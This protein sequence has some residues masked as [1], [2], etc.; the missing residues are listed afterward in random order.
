MPSEPDSPDNPDVETAARVFSVGNGR[1]VTFAPGNLQYHPA[2]NE[3]RFAENQTDYI[4]KPNGNISSTFDGWI[5]LFGWGTGDDPTKSSAEDA[6]YQTFV[7]WGTNQIG[8]DAP[9]T[10]RTLSKDEWMYIFYNRPNAQS[11][12]GL[13]TVDGVRGIIILPDNWKAPNGQGMSTETDAEGFHYINDFTYVRD[14]ISYDGDCDDIEF[15]SAQH[16]A[17]KLKA[18]VFCVENFYGL[19]EGQ[20]CAHFNVFSDINTDERIG[21]FNFCWEWYSIM[22]PDENQVFSFEYAYDYMAVGDTKQLTA[23]D[24]TTYTITIIDKVI[25]SNDSQKKI[26]F[27]LDRPF[28]FGGNSNG[29]VGVE[30]FRNRVQIKYVNP[31][32]SSDSASDSV[33]NANTDFVASTTQELSWRG[34]FYHNDE[35]NNFSHNVYTSEQWAKMEATG[36][37]FLPAGGYRDGYD[38]YF[39]AD[40]GAYWSSTEYDVEYAYFLYFN[41]YYC[42]PQNSFNRH[43]GFSVRLVKDAEQM[44]DL[45]DTPV[46]PE[47]PDAVGLITVKAKVPSD[48][49]DEIMVWVWYDGEDGREEPTTQEGDWYVYQQE[50]SE[51]NI[52]FKNGY[53]WQGYYYQTADITG[54]QPGEPYC[55]QIPEGES[56]PVPYL[57]D[58]DDDSSADPEEPVIPE[59]SVNDSYVPEAVDLGLSVRWAAYNVGANA[60]EEYGDYFAWGEVETKE[61]YTYQNYKWWT[62]GNIE[63]ITKYCSNHSY[64]TRD[65]KEELEAADDA[66]TANWGED[67]RMPTS[68]ELQELIDSCTWTWTTQNDVNGYEVLGPNGNSIFLP[69]AG[70]FSNALQYA[71]N[72][73]D[74]WTSSNNLRESYYSYDLGFSNFGYAKDKESFRYVGKSVRPVCTACSTSPNKPTN[75]DT[76]EEPSTPLDTLMGAFSVSATKMVTFSPGNLQYHPANNEWRFARTQLDYIGEANENTSSTYN[77][78]R[79]LFG[80]ND[81]GSGSNYVDYG[82]NKIDDYEP[83]TWRTLSLSE[84]R[85]L[86]FERANASSLYGVAQVNGVNGLILLPD[87]WSC[88]EGLTFNSGVSSYDFEYHQSFTLSQ[89]EIL[90][91]SGAVFLPAGGGSSGSYVYFLQSYGNY[92]SSTD[93]TGS[94]AYYFFFYADEVNTSNYYYSEGRNIRLVKDVATN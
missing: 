42:Y 81:C 49:T 40:L 39:T 44:P 23:E 36:A 84:W 27:S 83:N 3:W 4:Y 21:Q 89:W 34:E 82:T 86:A 53:G 65:N 5:D 46:D 94:W 43:L 9:N 10:W 58:C 68:A 20:S 38:V 51:L 52:I 12:F 90:E 78:W 16:P 32:P 15:Y 72:S 77:G 70:S 47:E 56:L 18:N 61:T 19:D 33:L 66:A 92:W 37:V 85:Y 31:N 48:W 11:L 24:G 30:R 74:Y 75:P 69:A 26:I 88:P 8:D 7:D 55:Y 29:S 67:W 59:D 28:Y 13:G 25:S 45:P 57:V 17:G 62:N 79:D 91:Q 41:S 35:G 60:P 73:G 14:L 76:P 22:L 6:D 63:Q 1:A 93:Y 80:W 2:N 54:L 71:G 50:G 87:N 64:G